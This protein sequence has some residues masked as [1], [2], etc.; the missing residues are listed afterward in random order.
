MDALYESKR[1]LIALYKKQREEFQD[2]R[3]R[4]RQETCKKREE[5]KRAQFAALAREM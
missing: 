4:K 3:E 2:I 1:Q 5:E